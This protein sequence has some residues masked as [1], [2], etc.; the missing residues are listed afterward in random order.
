MVPFSAE[1]EHKS[2][3]TGGGPPPLQF[4][5][6]FA[7]I[8][9]L[10]LSLAAP[11]YPRLGEFFPTESGNFLS[12]W[13]RGVT[14]VAPMNFGPNSS[15]PQGGGEET[16]SN[17]QFGPKE[18]NAGFEGS[19]GLFLVLVGIFCGF[20][21]LGFILW[22]FLVVGWVISSERWQIPPPP[23][24]GDPFLPNRARFQPGNFPKAGYSQNWVERRKKMSKVSHR[25][26][27]SPRQAR[28]FSFWHLFSPSQGWNWLFSEGKMGQ[29]SPKEGSWPPF[30]PEKSPKPRGKT[31]PDPT[32]S[33]NI[34][35]ENLFF[36]IGMPSKGGRELSSI[37]GLL[38]RVF[39]PLFGLLLRPIQASPTRGGQAPTHFSHSQGAKVKS[40]PPL[41]GGGQAMC[42][43]WY[44]CHSRGA[45]PR[46]GGFQLAFKVH[47]VVFSKAPDSPP[48]GGGVKRPFF[49][50]KYAQ[51]QSPLPEGGGGFQ[52]DF[53]DRYLAP[54][55]A[56]NPLFSKKGGKW[57]IFFGLAQGFCSKLCDFFPDFV[58]NSLSGSVQES[59]NRGDQA[60]TQH[61]PASHQFKQAK[62]QSLPPKGRG[63][64]TTI[65]LRQ[66]H[67]V[68]TSLCHTTRNRPQRGNFCVTLE[69]FSCKFFFWEKL[70]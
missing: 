28:N 38:Q 69:K 61:H 31:F 32:G 67:D 13:R 37:V 22:P 52:P 25:A 6:C 41:G 19:L 18:G 43:Y 65:L 11:I 68:I 55:K 57:R 54:T 33:R 5:T 4:P 53:R 34:T 29:K 48:R 45:P 16:A 63:G 8:S 58:Q 14:T 3:V 17:G 40:P 44:F 62:A 2:S 51:A 39:S 7:P 9:D 12:E 30:L 24:G 10:K 35:R 15:T 23:L 42:L 27:R 26:A 36:P 50:D 1:N 60:P 20:P 66:S 47:E 21:K 56:H 64:D 49:G 70:L 46:G 59:S